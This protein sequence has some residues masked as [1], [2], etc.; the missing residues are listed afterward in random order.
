MVR[1]SRDSFGAAPMND[2]AEHLV[3]LQHLHSQIAGLMREKRYDDADK[4]CAVAMSRL[5]R[6]HV[7]IKR[8][9]HPIA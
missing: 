3:A 5:A 6:L 7:A 9:S 8:I 2:Y 4:L 1:F